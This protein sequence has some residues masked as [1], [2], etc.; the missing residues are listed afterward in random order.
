MQR[1]KDIADCFQESSEKVKEASGEGAG[2]KA[3]LLCE[4]RYAGVGM[5]G[6]LQRSCWCGQWR[7]A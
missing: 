1:L 4:D 6:G 7:V 2:G 5:V 3:E